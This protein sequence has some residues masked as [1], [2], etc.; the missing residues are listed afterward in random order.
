MYSHYLSRRNPANS[1]TGRGVA[2]P[3]SGGKI[4]HMANGMLLLRKVR[5]LT[6]KLPHSESGPSSGRGRWQEKRG[7]GQKERGRRQVVFPSHDHQLQRTRVPSLVTA[8]S[9]QPR[10][11]PCTVA[12]PS[13]SHRHKG[14]ASG[15]LLQCLR[16]ANNGQSS[17]SRES[18]TVRSNE[19]TVASFDS[20]RLFAAFGGAD[21]EEA[22][23]SLRTRMKAEK[24]IG[25][26]VPS[27]QYTTGVQGGTFPISPHVAGGSLRTLTKAEKGIEDPMP[28]P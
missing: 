4:S 10:S 26:P 12:G 19:E 5:P 23:G 1:V 16:S 3:A 28:S 13:I 8:Q 18:L 7:R 15:H 24:G 25:D 2:M 9:K 20:S 11:K 14:A 27:P 6:K 17:G 21:G 22:G